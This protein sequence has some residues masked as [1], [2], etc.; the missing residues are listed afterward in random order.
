MSLGDGSIASLCIYEHRMYIVFIYNK[1]I[2]ILPRTTTSTVNLFVICSFT[3][4]FIV[5]WGFNV[6]IPHL[7]NSLDII[8]MRSSVKS[9]R[10]GRHRTDVCSIHQVARTP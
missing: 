9:W 3:L 10:G 7:F 4:S 1:F 8:N 5:Q 2:V 6:Y